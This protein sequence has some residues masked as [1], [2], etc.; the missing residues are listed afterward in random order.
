MAKEIWDK[1]TGEVLV[2]PD[3]V[4][5]YI[6]EMCL[7]KGMTSAQTRMFNFMLMNMNWENVVCYGARTKEKFM[8]ESG[9]KKPDV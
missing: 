6:K 1:E 4:K 3:F 8:T 2:E 5:L 9:M 7:V